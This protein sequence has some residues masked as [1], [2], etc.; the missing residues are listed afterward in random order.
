MPKIEKKQKLPN[1]FN[2][3]VVTTLTTEPNGLLDITLHN[4]QIFGVQSVK[5][6]QYI[7]AVVKKQFFFY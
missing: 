7:Y 6:I 5:Y 2:L 4:T 1:S 3:T